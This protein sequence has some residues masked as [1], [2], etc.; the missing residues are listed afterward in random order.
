MMKYS[1]CTWDLAP[2]LE[3]ASPASCPAS[4]H[5]HQW[6]HPPKQLTKNKQKILKNNQIPN[7]SNQ[8]QNKKFKEYDTHRQYP[9][10]NPNINKASL[11]TMIVVSLPQMKQC[12]GCGSVRNDEIFNLH[13]GCDVGPWVCIICFLQDTNHIQCLHPSKRLAKKK[14]KLMKKKQTPSK[15]Y[16]IVLAHKHR[17]QG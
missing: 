6:L 17:T 16:H 2:T 11:N 10:P 9:H 3:S 8:K 12:S 1:T 5:P 7:K 15:L 14:Q 13:L 4:S